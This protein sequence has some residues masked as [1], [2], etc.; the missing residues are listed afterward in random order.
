MNRKL[1]VIVLIALTVPILGYSYFAR[2]SELEGEIKVSGAWALYPMMVKWTEEYQKLHPK[3]KI[4][5]SAGG[6]GKGM[7]DAL[8]GLVDLGMISRDIYAEEIAKGAYYVVV[9]RG[10][11]VA[12]VNDDNPI[13]NDLLTK[14]ATKQCFYNIYIAGNVTTWGQVIGRPSVTDVVHVYTRSDSAGAAETWAKYLDKRQ[15]DL[16]GI[17]VYGDPGL[18]E[19]V[20]KD[21]LGIAFNNIGY[22]YDLKTKKQVQGIRVVPIDTNENGRI[23]PEEDFYSTKDRIVEGIG[24]GAFPSSAIN[25]LHLVAK[26]KF[27]GVTRE[28]VKWI[29]TD[30]QEY[31]D[32]AGFLPLSE[33]VIGEQLKKLG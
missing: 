10:A 2:V 19:A 28:F 14:G 17:G 4:E 18:L 12:T 20:R 5:V 13:L 6:A 3:I 26:S 32:E 1:V 33:D 21:R 31:V 7:A 30:G 29:L 23:D 27:T 11:V 8:G 24:R 22:A 9:T 25:N 15:E 16:G